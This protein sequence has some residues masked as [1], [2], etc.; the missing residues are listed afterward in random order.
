MS[1]TEEIFGDLRGMVRQILNEQIFFFQEHPAKVKEVTESGTN[2]S[3]IRVFCEVRNPGKSESDS[4]FWLPA[5]PGCLQYS[6]SPP[7]VGDVVTIY[8]PDKTPDRVFYKGFDPME[9]VFKKSGEDLKVLFEYKDGDD[10]TAIYFDKSEK[11]IVL[12]FGDTKFRQKL[13]KFILNIGSAPNSIEITDEGII[14]KDAMDVK[15]QPSGRSAKTDGYMTVM[16]PTVSRIP[17][18]HP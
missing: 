17:G 3:M 10:L 7:D 15:F 1:R 8:F 18:L 13:D 2:R 5:F 4:Q 16:G 12:E 9:Y 6:N 11:E 14:V